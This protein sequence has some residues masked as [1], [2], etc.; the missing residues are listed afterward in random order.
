MSPTITTPAMTQAGMILGTAAYM[1]PEQ[2]RGK[3]VDK[4]ADIWAFGCVLFEMLTGHRAFR[5]RGRHRHARGGPARGAG[6]EHCCRRRSRR[7]RSCSCVEACRKTRSSASATSSDVRLALEGA[8]ETAAPQTTA[9]ATSPSPR[10]TRVGVADRRGCRARHGGGSRVPAV[11]Y[12]RETPPPETARRDRHARHR[13]SDFLRPLARRPADRLRGFRRRRLPPLAAVPGSTTA[14]PLAGTEG[15]ASPFW[16]PDSRSV[17]FF[18]DGKL[19]RLDIGGGAP[20]TL[21]AARSCSR[22]DLERGRRHSVCANARRSA[23]PRAGLGRRSRGRDEARPA[24]EPPVS[25]LPARWP[26]IPVLRAGDAGN[27]RDLPGLARLGR[28]QAADAG[29]YG[30]R[31]PVIRD[32][33]C[34]CARERSWPSVWTWN[35]RRSPA[36]R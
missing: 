13:R 20:Q 1:S 21:A 28:N 2:A 31:L 32:G 19:K 24:D 36:I 35:G 6:L 14:Q 10:G 5:R 23:V 4:R 30:G 17:G 33:S 25:L 9:P 3:T 29:R 11:R 16:S 8:F 34:G 12:L 18:A 15:A 22:R 7:R 27:S 26:A